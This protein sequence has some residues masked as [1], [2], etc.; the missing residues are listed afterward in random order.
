[1]HRTVRPVAAVLAGVALLGA[2]GCGQ[3]A[4]KVAEKAT[5][6]AIESQAGDGA[7]V[8]IGQDGTFEI[9]TEEGSYSAGTGE[10]PEGWPDDVPLP[11]GLEIVT[12]SNLGNDAER[13]TSVIGTTDESPDA[14]AAFYEEAL[15]DWE[16]AS[17]MDSNAD[18]ASFRSVSYT[19][20]ERTLQLTIS[21]DAEGVTTLSV[22]HAV[23]AAA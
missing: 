21:E 9:E 19:S 5:E 22:T 14:V 11:D 8:D 16:E 17:S 6:E 18:G 12:G 1:M 23:K 3:A 4:E 7:K 10:V 20:G 2:A 15:S 13:I